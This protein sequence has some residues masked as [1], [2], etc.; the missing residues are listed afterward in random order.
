MDLRA[1]PQ[2]NAD[3]LV[4]ASPYDLVV[5]NALRGGALSALR[6]TSIVEY[7][8]S[9]LAFMEGHVNFRSG[10][11]FDGFAGS[12]NFADNYADNYAEFNNNGAEEYTS[13]ILMN[14]NA[15]G[16]EHLYEHQH[17]P[18]IYPV[19][20]IH[21]S[22]NDS[23]RKPAHLRFA[24]LREIQRV[25]PPAP[26]GSEAP[27]QSTEENP[28]ENTMSFRHLNWKRVGF[29]DK[30]MSMLNL[31]LMHFHEQTFNGLTDVSIRATLLLLITY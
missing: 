19:G 16:V 27:P 23:I 25:T 24:D 18:D 29:L 10:E 6:R 4:G 7:E 22:R 28:K 12:D 13:S 8:N 1:A 3:R 31:H 9:D 15:A 5:E 30:G 21:Y 17:E 11:T 2:F 20:P 14:R 26:L